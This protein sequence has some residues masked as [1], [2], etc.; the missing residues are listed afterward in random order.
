VAAVERLDEKAREGG[1]PLADH[2]FPFPVKIMVQ[3]GNSLVERPGRQVGSDWVV[4]MAPG[5]EYAVRIANKTGGPVLMRLLVDGLNTR[6]EKDELKGVST[7]VAGMRVNLDQARPW[8]LDPGLPGVFKQNGV[9]LWDLKGFEKAESETA[10]S[11]FGRFTV[12]DVAS[13]LA[14][15]RGFT[16]QIGTITAA[17]YKPRKPGD[18]GAIGTDAGRTHRERV[19]IVKGYEVGPMLA[20]VTIR[21][22]AKDQR[23]PE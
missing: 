4:E 2:A 15:R 16:D 11:E 8:V 1:H 3:R 7:M 9:P 14:Q 12:V 18:R 20:V 22:V 13:S 23:K 21:Y 19:R 5:E 17:F 6:V 10:D